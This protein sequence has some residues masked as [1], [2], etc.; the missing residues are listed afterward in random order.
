MVCQRHRSSPAGSTESTSRA[1]S[2][3]AETFEE[4][5]RFS[6]VAVLTHSFQVKFSLPAQLLLSQA[7]VR[8][9]GGYVSFSARGDLI[10]DLHG[11]HRCTDGSEGIFTVSRFGSLPVKNTA[12]PE[13]PSAAHLLS[14][15]LL[16]G[17]HH[18]KHRVAFPGPEVVSLWTHAMINT[19][20]IHVEMTAVQTSLSCYTLQPQF[21]FSFFRAAMCPFARSTTW[22]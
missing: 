21:S 22:I 3:N 9:A 7:R 20:S 8:V 6:G 13:K 4:E 16:H 2:L 12:R 17:F 1:S 19:Y 15:S 10:R 5:I 14:R 11:K 18:L